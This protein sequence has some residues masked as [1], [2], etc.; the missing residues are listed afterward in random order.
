MNTKYKTIEELLKEFD[1]KGQCVQVCPLRSFAEMSTKLANSSSDDDIYQIIGESL[2]QLVPNSLVSINS[3]EKT[4]D[5]FYVKAIVGANTHITTLAKVLGKNPVGMSFAI[6]DVARRELSGESLKKV[7]GGLYSLTMGNIPKTVCTVIEKLLN[8]KNVYAIALTR[9]GELL[10]SASLLVQN[11]TDYMQPELI[12]TFVSLASISLQRWKAEEAFQKSELRNI[13]ALQAYSQA[14]ESSTD[15]IFTVDL[16]GNFLSTNKA[17][18][19]QLGYSE[20]EI[21]KIN[22]F[23]LVHSDDLS[24]VQRAFSRLIQGENVQNLEYR[25]RKKDGSY[26]NILNSS[27]AILDHE[28]NVVSAFGIARNI[29]E[30]KKEE[31]ELREHY[32]GLEQMVVEGTREL[33]L[34][35]KKLQQELRERKKAEEKARLSTQRLENLVTSSPVIMCKSD[36]KTKIL[37]VNR[38]FEEVTGYTADEV[39]G[40]YWPMVGI[41]EADKVA[42]L[43]RGIQKLAGKSPAPIEVKIRCKDGQLKYVSGIGEVIKENGIPVGYQVIAQDITERKKAE[44]EAK[45]STQRLLKALEDIV[46]AMVRTAELRDPYTAGHQRRVAQLACAIADEIG[47]PQDQLMGIRFAGLIHDIGKI[48]VPAEILTHPNGLTEAEMTIIMTHPNIGYEIL[49]DIEFPWPIAQT[50][51]Q[52][53][54][55]MNGSGYPQGLLKEDIIVEARILGVAD[56][57]EAMASHRPY[58]P[59]LGINKALEEIIHNSG[60]L[61]DTIA[62]ESCVRLFKKKGFKFSENDHEKY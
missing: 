23:Q 53:H 58:R 17:F 59:S 46:E 6:D 51:L 28:N 4:S 31:K 32:D 36:L 61:Y 22:G 60:K 24:S 56:V 34:T 15:M 7:P 5:L 19:S 27:C 52:H 41:V 54:E 9:K 57:V 43:Y 47:L 48:R 40:K 3:F 42:L 45:Q 38:K 13:Q 1:N 49:K 30:R 12:Q 25:Y 55:R 39:V 37:K 62:V 16:D 29:T 26:I 10:G 33:E 8:I 44:E 2:Y 20:Q 18:H 11:G 50:V 14:L 35:N 21:K